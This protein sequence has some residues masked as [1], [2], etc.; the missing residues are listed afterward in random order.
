MGP[1][2]QTPHPIFRPEPILLPVF[3][4]LFFIFSFF[5]CLFYFL[6]LQRRKV[7]KESTRLERGQVV[8]PLANAGKLQLILINLRFDCN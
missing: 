6:P 2:V 8:V 4:F 1:I 7:L 3:F 5:L